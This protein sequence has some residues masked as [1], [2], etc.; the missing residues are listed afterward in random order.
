ME[1]FHNSLK[2][3]A[4]VLWLHFCFLL[5]SD[6]LYP[7]RESNAE[8][9]LRRTLLYP[10]NY[11]GNCFCAAKVRIS[12]QK[13][14]FLGA[15]SCDGSHFLQCCFLTVGIAHLLHE[16]CEFCDERLVVAAFLQ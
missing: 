7:D 13:N 4:F 6:S 11:Q 5:L 12:E 1:Y 14:K 8:L 16:V 2:I 10:F 3:I 15:F 9:S